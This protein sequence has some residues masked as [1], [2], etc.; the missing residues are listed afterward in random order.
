MPTLRQ[1]SLPTG[2]TILEVLWSDGTLVAGGGAVDSGWIPL[3][4]LDSLRLIRRHAGGAYALE[5]DWSRD[6][7]TVDVTEVLGLANRTSGELAVA[8][9]YA[10]FR[11]RNTDALN[12]FTEH[13]TTV[14]AR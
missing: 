2:P 11:V 14:H 13:R 8:A 6:G 7:A 5:I 4:S 10:R 1:D 3:S 9:R 12:A